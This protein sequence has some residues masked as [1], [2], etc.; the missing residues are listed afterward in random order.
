MNIIEKKIYNLVKSKPWIKNIIRNIYQ[1]F[2]DVLPRKKEI[3]KNQ[4]DSKEGYFFGFHD[5]NPFSKSNNKVLSHK[6]LHDN[7]IIPKFGEKIDIGYF[8]LKN[9]KFEDFVKVDESSALNFHKGARLQWVDSNSLIFNTSCKNKLVSK[10]VNI[11]S[12]ESKIFDFPVDSI[13]KDGTLAS[14]FS[15]ERLNEFMPGYGYDGSI[16]DGFLQEKASSKTGIFIYSLKSKNLIKMISL[17]Q[18]LMLDKNGSTISK[19]NH[20]VTHSEFSKDGRYLSFLHR[21]VGDDIKKR[22]SKL[23]IYDMNEDRII[24]THTS[25]MVS[26]YVWNEKNEILA[27]CSISNIDGHYIIPIQDVI[28]ANHIAPSHLNSDGHQTFISNDKFI[29]DTYPDK[30]RMSKLKI[31][32]ILD[33]NVELLASI[34]SPKKFQTKDFKNHI[35]CDLHPRVSNDGSLVCFDAVRNNHRSLC[36]MNI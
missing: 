28:K 12:N 7:L 14:S 29:T 21:W 1:S 27:Y 5:V 31:V 18:L 30:F 9:K 36:I 22:K 4:I 33:N 25:G 24:E 15:Y 8:N 2:F 23:L 19:F 3:F 32:N 16:D 20:Y 17:K 6:L 34:Y 10:L 35:A 11:K 26:H 13:S